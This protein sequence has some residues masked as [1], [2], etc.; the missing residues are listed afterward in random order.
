MPGVAVLAKSNDN[1]ICPQSQTP[2]LVQLSR[3]L[4]VYER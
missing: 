1:L 2:E 4:Y 3:S